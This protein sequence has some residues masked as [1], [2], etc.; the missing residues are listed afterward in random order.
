M[1]FGDRLG[2]ASRTLGAWLNL[3]ARIRRS[4]LARPKPA[5]NIFPVTARMPLLILL[6]SITVNLPVK[7]AWSWGGGRRV[8]SQRGR[9]RK[10]QER[11]PRG[12][13]LGERE[14]QGGLGDAESD[15]G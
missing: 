6:F 10:R 4:T 3:N 13:G 15:C 12:E 11:R 1:A 14:P 7:L 8:G 9:D 5:N 2:L